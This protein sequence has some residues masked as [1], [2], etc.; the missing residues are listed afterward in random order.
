MTGGTRGPY[1]QGID[2]ATNDAIV[3]TEQD[4]ARK[5]AKYGMLNILCSV[6]KK[7]F[8]GRR[9][10]NIQNFLNFHCLGDLTNTVANVLLV[11]QS[12]L[13]AVN[14]DIKALPYALKAILGGLTGGLKSKGGLLNKVT[15]ALRGTTGGLVTATQKIW[16][17]A[18]L[19]GMRRKCRNL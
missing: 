13:N 6:L 11:P 12:Y 18:I 16:T 17:N 9:N 7:K 4:V 10:A 2:Q 3:Q 15:G 1:N 8:W 19:N 14:G 5:H